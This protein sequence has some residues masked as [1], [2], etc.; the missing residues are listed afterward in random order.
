[1]LRGGEE[2]DGRGE[3]GHVLQRGGCVDLLAQ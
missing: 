1:M 3:A 2:G